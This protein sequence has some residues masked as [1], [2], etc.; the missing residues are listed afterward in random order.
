MKVETT[1][2]WLCRGLQVLGYLALALW[3]LACPLLWIMRDGLGPRS[4]QTPGWAALWKFSPVLLIGL[5][6]VSYLVLLHFFSW[7]LLSRP[8]GPGQPRG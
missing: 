3:L 6:L 5:V 2:L 7:W 8:S 1:L 4:V